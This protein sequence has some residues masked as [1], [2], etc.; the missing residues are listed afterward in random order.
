MDEHPL[1]IGSHRLRKG[2]PLQSDVVLSDKQLQCLSDKYK[3]QF[4]SGRSEGG[5]PVCRTGR[6]AL[7]YKL[8]FQFAVGETFT[9]I[10]MNAMRMNQLGLFNI[11]KTSSVIQHATNTLILG[12]DRKLV[13]EMK[14]FYIGS[15]CPCSFQDY[16]T[17]CNVCLGNRTHSCLIVNQ[18][19]YNSL[20]DME[21]MLVYRDF[22]KIYIIGIDTDHKWEYGNEVEFKI[23][24]R[25]LLK[26]LALTIVSEIG[27][28]SKY[29]HQQCLWLKNSKWNSKHD[30][31][32][33][34]FEIKKLWNG[35]AE[36]LWVM[37][38][39]ELE[40]V[41]YSE[42]HPPQLREVERI[43]RCNFLWRKMGKLPI[44]CRHVT[45]D[46]GCRRGKSCAFWHPD[47]V[48]FKICFDQAC[49]CDAVH[50]IND[51]NKTFDTEVKFDNGLSIDLRDYP[52]RDCLKYPVLKEGQDKLFEVE[53]FYIQFY[54]IKTCLYI[55]C[56]PGEH[57]KQLLAYNKDLVIWGYDDTEC[58]IEHK[59]FHLIPERF[60]P[61]KMHQYVGIDGMISDIF[62][63]TDDDQGFEFFI[64]EQEK[65][66]HVIKP[67]SFLIKHILH[68]FSGLVPGNTV[69]PLIYGGSTEVRLMGRIGT[70]QMICDREL[71]R[72]LNFFNDEVRNK[73]GDD[74][75]DYFKMSESAFYDHNNSIM[76]RNDMLYPEFQTIEDIDSDAMA[77]FIIED[78][79]ITPRIIDNN[80]NALGQDVCSIV[81]Q[82]AN[83]LPLPTT[84]IVSV[85]NEPFVYKCICTEDG[86][87][88][89][90]SICDSD[91]DKDEEKASICDSYVNL[92]KVQPSSSGS[93]DFGDELRKS[94][95]LGLPFK[96]R[97]VTNSAPNLKSKYMNDDDDLMTLHHVA[98]SN[99]P[100]FRLPRQ[101]FLP[102]SIKS[103]KALSEQIVSVDHLESTEFKRDNKTEPILCE[104]CHIATDMEEDSVRSREDDGFDE[105]RKNFNSFKPPPN[106]PESKSIKGF[107]YMR[108]YRNYTWTSEQIDCHYDGNGV[109]N[110][111]YLE[112]EEYEFEHIEYNG[113]KI[114]KPFIKGKPRDKVKKELCI[115]N[116]FS[117]LD[118]VGQV[119]GCH[120]IYDEDDDKFWLD[121]D[122]DDFG[123][124]TE[125]DVKECK[126]ESDDESQWVVFPDFR[127]KM[128][129]KVVR[130][131]EHGYI[132]E[133]KTFQDKILP[134]LI[135]F[136][137]K[138]SFQQEYTINGKEMMVPMVVMSPLVNG[139]RIYFEFDGITKIM[140]ADLRGDILQSM[141]GVHKKTYNMDS[142][143]MV[144][145]K[146]LNSLSANKSWLSFYT[147][148][149][150]FCNK[151]INHAKVSYNG[152]SVLNTVNDLQGST[153]GR[154]Q[155]AKAHIQELSTFTNKK[156][157]EIFEASKIYVMMK[158]GYITE[159]QIRLLADLV[160]CK[161]F[162]HNSV[163][164]PCGSTITVTV[165][166]LEQSLVYTN[167]AMY[168]NLLDMMCSSLYYFK[169]KNIRTVWTIKK[170]FILSFLLIAITVV[171]TYIGNDLAMKFNHRHDG[172]DSS[173]QMMDNFVKHNNQ[174]WMD[175]IN[176]KRVVFDEEYVKKRD[177]LLHKVDDLTEKIKEDK[178]VKQFSNMMNSFGHKPHKQQISFESKR[179]RMQEIVD[180]YND[181]HK[182]RLIELDEDLNGS[183]RYYFLIIGS[184]LLLLCLPLCF[185]IKR[186]MVDR[187]FKYEAVGKAINGLPYEEFEYVKGDYILKNDVTVKGDIKNLDIPVKDSFI[188]RILPTLSVP[189]SLHINSVSNIVNSFMSRNARS[190]KPASWF[191]TPAYLQ[192]IASLK[193][194]AKTLY[195]GMGAINEADVPSF[196]EFLKGRKWD[197]AKKARFMRAPDVTHSIYVTKP[198]CKKEFVF[199]TALKA[200]RLINAPI[201]CFKKHSLHIWN[202]LAVHL[203]KALR[204]GSKFNN[205]S[206]HINFI[207]TSGMNRDQVGAQLKMILN[208]YASSSIRWV[209]VSS[210]FSKYEATQIAAILMCLIPMLK[211]ITR[212]WVQEMI[213]DSFSFIW[214]R[215]SS[216]VS[217]RGEEHQDV[218]FGYSATR[219]SG[220]DDTWFNNT[221]LGTCLMDWLLV[222]YENKKDVYLF[223]NGDD[224][225]LIGPE[226][227]QDY[228]DMSKIDNL[229]MKLKQVTL[230]GVENQDYCSSY[231]VE[232]L[233]TDKDGIVVDSEPTYLCTSKIGRILSKSGLTFQ[234][235]EKFSK[236]ELGCLAF[237]K[238]S[239]VAQETQVFPGISQFF[240]RVATQYM[241]YSNIKIKHCMKRFTDFTTKGKYKVTEYGIF[242]ICNRYN[243][244]RAEYDLLNLTFSQFD[245]KINNLSKQTGYDV[246]KE[247]LG[248]FVEKDIGVYEEEEIDD[249]HK[250]FDAEFLQEYCDL[251]AVDELQRKNSNLQIDRSFKSN[252]LIDS[253]QV[254]VK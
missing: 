115:S 69:L 59:R 250:Y 57:I 33:Y 27:S 15:Q 140:F 178:T 182:R 40:D 124:D 118:G 222:D 72:R 141:N 52:E 74:A 254:V 231:F 126:H 253:I 184:L 236:K 214:G 39:T 247:I 145:H 166:K 149:K 160:L 50:N 187:G 3:I 48:N 112:D 219:T 110:G 53:N 97:K 185:V 67:R 120:W 73:F 125:D 249:F 189:V 61:Y 180:D 45:T 142:L 227:F 150:D 34:R 121:P 138:R 1:L 13:K 94:R 92:P 54:G 117:Y 62:D 122:D 78:A 212:G 7:L 224:S 204:F 207:T 248:K 8:F 158:Q 37:T 203:K 79:T 17:G 206:K 202:R 127:D 165:S 139:N 154:L 38:K 156:F 9:V 106:T 246:I 238:A 217:V 56:G 84:P 225:F 132:F 10:G 210:D 43:H 148:H 220:D 196:D 252:V 90:K 102:Y 251:M 41:D 29:Y 211:R 223:Q 163:C 244:T 30:G 239:A 109:L 133:E 24:K 205:I 65:F 81:S 137:I 143:R 242:Q 229:G 44:P 100:Q 23:I 208:K 104:S 136:E 232:V 64:E 218:Q 129:Y 175:Y 161:E 114:S 173:V 164:L 87:D 101:R 199:K 83:D 221:T 195:E 172:S 14:K 128:F 152:E 5:H 46:L 233:S 71:E 243:I 197:K 111:D 198:F 192:T 240:D 213:I 193:N 93:E 26:N 60:D 68:D 76:Y 113:D 146:Y 58:L 216:Y 241:Q 49:D 245:P 235:V 209:C 176:E 20:L 170:W 28:K 135:D 18:H 226:G 107:L 103:V 157:H 119:R 130:V 183:F 105:F 147:Q 12:S 6:L 25:T 144:F 70:E 88:E 181:T 95:S 66:I 159:Q 63:E 167:S 82:F 22:E 162:T 51:I 234:N 186:L 89:E 153:L 123:F 11:A 230:D 96:W 55:G 99:T 174:E 134:N 36:N 42:C 19:Y 215:K 2:M 131:T 98:L 85:K 194:H 75:L 201:D 116:S 4:L 179:G 151:L 108:P 228:M 191:K 47:T 35:F 190:L 32:N 171:A 168:I 237:Q 177:K 188:Y 86:K 21:R 80:N 155:R 91:D 77:E 200:G 169:V 31:C 16:I